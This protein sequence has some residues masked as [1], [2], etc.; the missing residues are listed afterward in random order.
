MTCQSNDKGKFSG[1][2][3]LYKDG[4]IIKEEIIKDFV[5]FQQKK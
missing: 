4:E 5:K 3:T 2:R 1:K